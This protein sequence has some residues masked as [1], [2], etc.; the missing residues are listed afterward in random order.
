MLEDWEPSFTIKEILL[1]IQDVLFLGI[2]SVSE[3]LLDKSS[4]DSTYLIWKL[5]F[6]ES[7]VYEIVSMYN[8]IVSFHVSQCIYNRSTNLWGYDQHRSD[9]F[10]EW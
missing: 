7:N 6:V 2:K 9:T 3:E 4:S 1:A 10:E 5:F 8:K